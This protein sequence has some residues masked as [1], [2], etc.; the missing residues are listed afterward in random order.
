MR[1]S[2]S[3]EDLAVYKAKEVPSFLS[4]FKNLSTVK[5]RD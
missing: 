4:Y 3:R 1:S 2:E 5:R